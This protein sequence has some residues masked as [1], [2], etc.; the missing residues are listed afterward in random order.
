VQLTL[1]GRGEKEEVRT[2]QELNGFEQALAWLSDEEYLL[3]AYNMNGKTLSAGKHALLYIGDA[4]ITQLR[5][6]DAI[7]HP[8]NVIAGEGT[9]NIEVMGS[10]VQRQEGIYDLQGRK[11]STL[12]ATPYSQREN[13]QFSTLKKGVYII[14]GQKVVK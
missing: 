10:R 3:L 2:T 13:S 4:D 8:V 7:G 11:L 6:A 5:L 12:I 9:T 14:N 1:D